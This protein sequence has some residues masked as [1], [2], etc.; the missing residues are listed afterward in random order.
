MLKNMERKKAKLEKQIAELKAQEMNVDLIEVKKDRLI[1]EEEPATESAAETDTK[2][3][4]SQG[5]E[6][7]EAPPSAAPSGSSAFGF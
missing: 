6:S 2:S 7:A 1:K 5:A 4:T 3:R